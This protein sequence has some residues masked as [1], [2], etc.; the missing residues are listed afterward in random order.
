MAEFTDLET[1]EMMF[2]LS[3]SALFVIPGFFGLILAIVARG[4]VAAQPFLTGGALAFLAILC[5]L[6]FLGISAHQ[7]VDAYTHYDY[8]KAVEGRVRAGDPEVVTTLRQK[9]TGPE[10]RKAFR[11]AAQMK[12]DRALAFFTW[13]LSGGARGEERHALRYMAELSRRGKAEAVRQIFSQILADPSRPLDLR[14]QVLAA[15]PG[16]PEAHFLTIVRAGAAD[17]TAAVRSSAAKALG[18]TKVAGAA[19]VLVGLCHDPDEKVAATAAQS[20]ARGAWKGT[21]DERVG[22]LGELLVKASHR[23]VREQAVRALEK[24][25]RS[26]NPFPLVA[27]QYLS[28]A[29]KNDSDPRIQERAAEALDR[30]QKRLAKAKHKIKRKIKVR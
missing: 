7:W 16:L 14:R 22:L 21:L 17:E 30:A 15:S 24:F 9:A 12:P 26:D 6:T 28:H 5:N 23:E 3:F 10:S 27:M 13:A 8:W 25:V 20:L 18:Q 29:A 2:V 11:L 19:D 4:R 1:A